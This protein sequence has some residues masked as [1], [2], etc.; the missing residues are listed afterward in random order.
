MLKNA[1][2]DVIVKDTFKVRCNNLA[3]A[4]KYFLVRQNV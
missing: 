1:N 3:H 2:M 4:V